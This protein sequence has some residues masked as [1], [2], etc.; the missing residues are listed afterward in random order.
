MPFGGIMKTVLDAC[1]QCNVG[2]CNH[3]FTKKWQ[4][5]PQVQEALTAAFTMVGNMPTVSV[6]PG[7]GC[8]GEVAISNMH[9]TIGD[10]AVVVSGAF[11]YEEGVLTLTAKGTAGGLALSSWLS[12]SDFELNAKVDIKRGSFLGGSASGS[13]Q[14]LSQQTEFESKLMFSWSKGKGVTATGTVHLPSVQVS[15]DIELK[16]SSVN[17]E[18]S[19][20]NISGS[21]ATTVVVQ[22]TSKGSPLMV[23][24]NVDFART[25]G[26]DSVQLNGQLTGMVHGIIPDADFVSIGELKVAAAWKNGTFGDW[27]LQGD[28]CLGDEHSC[29]N[30]KASAETVVG[31]LTMTDDPGAGMH[32][33]A[34]ISSTKLGSLIAIVSNHDIAAEVPATIA[35]TELSHTTISY[36]EASGLL[37]EGDFTWASDTVYMT[38][39]AGGSP[40][41]WAIEL[42]KASGSDMVGQLKVEGQNGSKHLLSLGRNASADKLWYNI[43]FDEAIYF[44]ANALVYEVPKL[45]APLQ[46][47][48]SHIEASI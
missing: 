19:P 33:N 9:I 4:N 5:N 27:S 21:M 25:G 17:L 28:I 3:N 35:S 44:G 12:M 41:Q 38:L 7:S 6:S 32:I 34:K 24:V 46:K 13:V 1:K 20:G 48:I 36:S 22:A 43:S 42:M 23:Q 8:G 26:Q 31:Q 14:V 18:Y 39:S 47:A 15:N 10:K 11:T 16:S 30:A 2:I 29:K 40:F 37:M 45:K